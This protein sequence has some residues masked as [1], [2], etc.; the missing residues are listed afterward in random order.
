MRNKINTFCLFR[1]ISIIMFGVAAQAQEGVQTS[2]HHHYESIRAL[3]MGDAFIASTD[4]YS[5]LFYNP[6]A[7]ARRESGQINLA[8]DAGWTAETTNLSKD[9]SDVSSKNT[10]TDA[11]KYNA[12]SE[13]LQKYYGKTFTI[14]AKVFEG[15]WVRPNWGFGIV[16][17][18]VT[19]DMQIHNQAAPSVD[20]RTYVDT[21]IAYA[22][23]K[24][25]KGLVP[26]RLSVGSNFKLINRGYANRQF[27]ALDFVA[28]SQVLKKEDLRDGYTFDMDWGTLYTPEVPSEGVL[29]VFQL[30]KPTFAAVVRN[31]VDMG[32]KNTMHLMS[33]DQVEAPERLYRVLDVGAKFE[34][35]SL[36]IFGGRG[37]L[38]VRD[39]GHPNFTT[40]R[41]L[42][43]GFEF[44]W[45]VTT[46]WR[47]H[48]RV[49]LNQGYYTAGISAMLFIFN[50]DFAT[51]GEEV[52]SYSQPKENRIYMAKLN[53]DI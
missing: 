16:P 28:D 3:G 42:H 40:R 6:A 41:A 32:F 45:S 31:V 46:W 26:G 50:L 20:I 27:N 14:R 17:A 37:E 49:G 36:W 7:L 2:I 22:Y 52:G 1:V 4:D 33:K 13:L 38:D 19:L 5:A 30:A 8:I 12:Y 10:T 44:D 53:I 21:T 24:D 35:P 34:Y 39:I 29:S 25:L 15:I 43:V 51:Y 18:D 47:G 48:Y 9:F 11:D 23:A